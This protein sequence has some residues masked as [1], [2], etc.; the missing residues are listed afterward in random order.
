M[1]IDE[2]LQQAVDAV[3]DQQLSSIQ[4]TIKGQQEDGRGGMRT[5]NIVITFQGDEAH[6]FLAHPSYKTLANAYGLWDDFFL[7][8]IEG[9]GIEVDSVHITT[10]TEQ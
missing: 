3:R 1:Y 9:D 4:V 7:G 6:Q 5:R 10:L 2:K 8:T